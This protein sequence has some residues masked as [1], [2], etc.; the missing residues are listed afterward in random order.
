MELKDLR[1]QIDTI[2]NALLSFFIKRMQL[3][4]E[5][6]KLKKERGLAIYNAEREQEILDWVSR[7][8]GDLECYARLFFSCLFELSRSR[9]SQIISENRMIDNPEN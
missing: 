7:E 1:D 2:D 4:D 9:Q 6:A 8:S 5:V 3:T